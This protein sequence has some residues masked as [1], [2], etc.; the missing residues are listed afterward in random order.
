MNY[1]RLLA[2]SLGYLFMAITTFAQSP[3]R[4]F[5]ISVGGG[6]QDY[7]SSLGNSFKVSSPG[8]HGAGD[9]L[10]GTYVNHSLDIVFSGSI[11][12]LGSTR[13]KSL[14]MSLKYKLADDRFLPETSTL[15]P[16]IFLGAS[17][18]NLSDRVLIKPIYNASFMTL[19]AG[20]GV[21]YYVYKRVSLG[22]HLS[23]GYFLVDNADSKTHS[24]PSEVYIHNALMLGIDVFKMEE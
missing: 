5:G 10:I 4:R 6:P 7:K 18:S 14:G 21:R 20:L 9:L 11:G 3:E 1:K 12:D 23:F 15:K 13:L 17:F 24:N 16:Y 19:N 8:W 22:Y 2:F